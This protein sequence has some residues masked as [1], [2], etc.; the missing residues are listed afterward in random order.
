MIVEIIFIIKNNTVVLITK[1]SGEM[2]RSFDVLISYRCIDVVVFIFVEE[3]IGKI[4]NTTS[5]HEYTTDLSVD[6][7]L[8]MDVTIVNNIVNPF[9]EFLS[10]NC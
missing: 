6:L 10:S 9:N 8:K 5:T 7:A 3:Y 4:W 1:H 2:C